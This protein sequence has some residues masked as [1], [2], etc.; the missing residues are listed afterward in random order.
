MRALQ[1]QGGVGGSVPGWGAPQRSGKLL[2]LQQ[3][4]P[5]WKEAGHRVLV[6]T[7]VS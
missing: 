7:Q 2:V 5:L 4:L 3:I 1:E 6:F